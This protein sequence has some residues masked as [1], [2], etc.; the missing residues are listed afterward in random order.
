MVSPIHHGLE[1][2][3]GVELIVRLAVSAES[4]DALRLVCRSSGPSFVKLGPRPIDIIRAG[5]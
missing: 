5:R 2:S 1:H 3:K 4:S